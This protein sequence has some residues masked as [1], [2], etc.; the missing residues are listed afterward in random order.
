MNLLT[1]DIPGRRRLRA[2]MVGGGRGSFFAS[3]HRTAM[4]LTNR[5][6]LVAG[7][8]SSDRQTSI[9]AGEA[10]GVARDRTYPSF[11]DMAAAEAARDDGI[12]VAIIVT[13][14][15]LHFEPCKS[16]LEAG[17]PVICEKPLVHSSEQAR[18]LQRIAAANET[19]F[20]VTYTYT[21]YPMVRDAR[22]RIRAGEIGQVRFMHVEYLLEWLV[23]DPSK[24]GKGGIWRGDPERA[25]PT[26]ALGDIGTHAFNILEFVSG[27]RCT[28]LNA[29][30][31]QTVDSFGL[32]DTD[33]VQLEFEGGANGVLW[34][35]FAAPGHRNGLRFKIVGSKATLEWR[36]EAPETLTM[37]RLGESDLT[38][39]RGH[40]DISSDAKLAT[41]LP[42]GSPEGYL[43]ALAVLYSD[44]ATALEAGRNWRE[45]LPVPIP[46]VYEGLRGVLLSEIS[47]RSSASKSWVSFPR[48]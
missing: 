31:L 3:R 19:F 15:H 9:E 12:E 42:A 32:D 4:R 36:Q 44:Y 27:L 37:S 38:Y 7:S 26:G 22:A 20:A 11:T 40:A 48:S 1:D 16:F 34:S 10:L 43:E 45:V 6:E 41:S 25:G 30:L 14:N 24:L 17:I 13:P 47:V 18:E 46:D 33:V 2:G 35:S 8:F 28:A 5:F 29:N 39:R 23:N 21:G